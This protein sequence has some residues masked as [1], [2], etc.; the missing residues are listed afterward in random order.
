MTEFARATEKLT[1]L[2][3]LCEELLNCPSEEL[4]LKVERYHTLFQSV[5][6]LSGVITKYRMQLAEK[7]PDKRYYGPKMLGKVQELVERYDVLYE[8]CEDELK[9][10][11]GPILEAKLQ[12][13]EMAKAKALQ[14]LEMQRL[15]RVNEG[16]TET[17]SEMAM[18]EEDVR[19]KQAEEAEARTRA[20]EVT[21]GEVKRQAE[22]AERL[23]RLE[24]ELIEMDNRMEGMKEIDRLFFALSHL[25][26]HP[27][28]SSAAAVQSFR[29]V[30]ETIHDCVAEIAKN[31]DNI[32]SRVYRFWNELF[33]S[34][35]ASKPG[36]MTV[37]RVVGFRMVAAKDIEAVL[38]K[39]GRL[40]DMSEEVYLYMQE[41]DINEQYEQWVGWIDK[42]E[43]TKDILGALSS[44]VRTRALA[45]K[46]SVGTRLS[47]EEL[48][49]MLNDFKTQVSV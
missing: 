36:A 6:T 37:L 1:E 14:E 46:S 45:G 7:D 23:R 29:D 25:L 38:R 49:S 24:A 34:N 26:H 42:M 47:V 43:K 8:V 32:T 44:R 39:L 40:P 30:L 16:R 11:Y 19:R 27:A 13:Q 9:P 15:D 22:Q 48:S 33:Q 12:Q 41:P 21:E 10:S 17:S 5:A 28:N 31:P 20:D 35:I 4:H 2:K 18:R 3:E